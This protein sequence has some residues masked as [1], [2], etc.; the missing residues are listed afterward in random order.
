[1][2]IPGLPIKQGLY[3]PRNEKDGCGVGFV[4]NIKGQKSHTIVEQGLQVLENLT[5]RG[6]QGCDPC[7]G[8]GA[9]I[10]LQIPHSFLKQATASESFTLPKAGEYGVGMVFLPQE[11]HS[12]QQCQKVFENVIRE[13]GS[14]L[15]GWRDVPVKSE[16]IGV[17]ARQTE[18]VIRQVF[19]ARDILNEAQF[20]RKLYVIRKRVE[21]AIRDT[22]IPQRDYFYISSLSGNTIVYKGLLLPHQMTAY[23]QDLKDPQFVSAM[24]LVHSRFST[25]TF[26]TWPLSHPYRFTCHNGEIN[27]LKGNVNWMRARHGRLQSE[28]F[29]EDVDKLFP[30]V[31]PDQSDSACLDNALEF[32]VLG[33]RSLPHA[34]MMLI[35]EPWVGNPHMNLDRRGFYEYHA[36][37]MEPW[38]GP[39]AVCFTDGK[40]IGATL[41][42]NGLRPCRY[43]V[44]TDDTVVL[45][46]EAGVLP[47]DP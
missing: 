23:Y 13:E 3:D 9:G 44:M 21:Q 40:L 43:Q 5:H 11:E 35:P 16:A 29:G 26:P 2:N 24:A 33:G 19:L 31:F 38:D 30:I 15:L 37:V 34:M 14:R 46:S 47:V 10:L 8:D 36:A 17:Q 41:D 25:N 18:P 32:L 28:L 45:A 4:V 42:R 22:A 6:A 7:T 20:E 12:R 39:A 27:T 1:M